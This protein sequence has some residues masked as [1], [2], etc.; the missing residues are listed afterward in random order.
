MLM[1][2]LECKLLLSPALRFSHF[3]LSHLRCHF[4][5]LILVLALTLQDLL[6]LFEL[7][8]HASQLLFI[9]LISLLIMQHMVQA[10]FSNLTALVQ[11]EIF[12]KHFLANLMHARNHRLKLL[13][14]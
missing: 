12:S 3:H 7:R 5:Y 4:G 11:I 13:N 1:T 9:T 10:F 8:S 2:C 6:E 14:V